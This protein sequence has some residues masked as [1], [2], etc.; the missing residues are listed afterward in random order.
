MQTLT[1]LVS[2]RYQSQKLFRTICHKQFTFFPS[3]S[4]SRVRALLSM[5]LCLSSSSATFGEAGRPG[6]LRP[7]QGAP[8]APVR[9]MQS[10]GLLLPP[11]A[12]KEQSLSLHPSPPHVL[13]PPHLSPS[14]FP[15]FSGHLP[16]QIISPSKRR[17]EP[18]DSPSAAAAVVVGLSGLPRLWRSLAQCLQ[19][20]AFHFP[21]K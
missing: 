8:A 3:V 1:D 5:L 12:I 17:P 6:R 7:E 16:E 10:P 20:C 18:A 13:T 11:R 15:L 2:H 4:S 9:E 21:A 14:L 19:R